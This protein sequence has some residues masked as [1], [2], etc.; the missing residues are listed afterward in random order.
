MVVSN[1]W[2][3]TQFSKTSTGSSINFRRINTAKEIIIPIV[4]VRTDKGELTEGAISRIEKMKQTF[5]SSSDSKKKKENSTIEE[6]I[7]P[8]DQILFQNC[9]KVFIDKLGKKVIPYWEFPNGCW[10]NEKARE[11]DLTLKK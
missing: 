5:L 11:L 6:D 7:I 10:D 1:L 9:V 3:V 2:Q 4:E 8:Y